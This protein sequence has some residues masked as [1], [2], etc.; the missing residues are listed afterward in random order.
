MAKLLTEQIQD[1]IVE[2]HAFYFRPTRI[3]ELVKEEFPNFTGEISRQLVRTYN[4]LQNPK[5]ATRHAA[6]F[7]A[8]RKK[9]R[10]SA[11]EIPIAIQT[12]RLRELD[13]ELNRA[14]RNVDLK[15]RI[16]KQA[17]E[18]IG[19]VFTNRREISGQ[20]GA[21]I[22]YENVSRRER[23]EE[24]LNKFMTIDDNGKPR[25]KV[26]TRK[27]AIEQARAGGLTLLL[28]YLGEDG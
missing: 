21:P 11:G 14:G 23:A 28:E 1:F 3:I 15:L 2:R 22:Q 20:G 27:T 4:P 24:I 7:E 8:C 10:E 17:A 16:L 9:F 6:Y 25:K 19:G 26:L 12:V 18:E 13:D 5:I